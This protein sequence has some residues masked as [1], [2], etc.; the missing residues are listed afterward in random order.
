MATEHKTTGLWMRPLSFAGLH[1]ILRTVAEYPAGLA[2]SEIDAAIRKRR[3]YLTQRGSVP[4]R[5]TLYHCRNTLLRLQALIRR[6]KRLVVNEAHPGVGTLLR[7]GPPSADLLEPDAREAFAGLVLANPDC[8]RHFFDLFLPTAAT[9]G[10]EEFRKQGCS[11][12][13]RNQ[14][15]RGRKCVVI[16]ALDGWPSIVLRSPSEVKSIL[17][18]VR[19]WARDQ[20][21]LVDEF[22]HEGAGVVMYP[23]LTPGDH[24]SVRQVVEEIVALLSPDTDWTTLSIRDLIVHCCQQARRP[25]TDLFNAIKWLTNEFPGYVGLIPT[26]RSM[27]TLT[28]RSIQ[29]EDLEL[30]SYFRDAQGRFASHIRVHSHVREAESCA[31]S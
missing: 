9:Y 8:K 25:L 22:Y 16:E 30:R 28:A 21:M 19:Y 13:W 4:K 31:Q 24:S 29:R 14:R 12:A 10:A 3:L 15:E 20:L 2:A 6:G 23:I 18:G 17:Y 7:V 11:V 27:A 26:S 5:T 1:R